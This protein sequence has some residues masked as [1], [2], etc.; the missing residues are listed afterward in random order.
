MKYEVDVIVDNRVWRTK[1]FDNEKD[2]E[3]FRD[4]F[5]ITSMNSVAV[6]P[7]EVDSDAYTE[8]R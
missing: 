3:Y 8:K 4:S 2:A 7:K 5:N 6:G 1:E